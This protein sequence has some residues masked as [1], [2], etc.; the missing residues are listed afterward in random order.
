MAR[1]RHDGDCTFYSSLVNGRVE[2]GI[3]TCGYGRQVLRRDNDDGEMYS[4]E[5]RAKLE[6]EV[7]KANDGGLAGKVGGDNGQN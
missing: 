7:K 4:P 5:L 1:G 6:S 3:C 2:D